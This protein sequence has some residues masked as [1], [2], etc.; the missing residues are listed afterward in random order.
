MDTFMECLND[1]AS[2]FKDQGRTKEIL[3]VMTEIETV[4]KNYEDIVKEF[5]EI[6][7]MPDSETE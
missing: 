7:L 4:E 5:H 3:T 6:G 1:L 2:E